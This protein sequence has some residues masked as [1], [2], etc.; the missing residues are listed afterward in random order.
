MRQRIAIDMDETIVDTMTRHVDW[1][2]NEFGQQLT[3]ADLHGTKIYHCVAAEHVACVRAY[4]DH[5]D[6]FADIPPYENALEVVRELSERYDVF[7]ATAAMEHPNSFAAKYTWLTKNMPFLSPM[8]FIFC[9]NKGVL[10][11]DYL[12]DDSP[13]HFEYFRGESILFSA[14]HNMLEIHPKRV[15]SWQEVRGLFL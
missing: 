11:T 7:I 14:P 3:K 12:I 4:P 5:P 10:H 2:N 13:R 9:G 15:N 1:Y 8:N 6:F